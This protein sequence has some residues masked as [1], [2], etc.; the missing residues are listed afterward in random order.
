MKFAGEAGF[1]NVIDATVHAEE[2]EGHFWQVF[3]DVAG[4]DKRIK[5]S[6]VNDGA[7]LGHRPGASVKLGFSADLAVALPEGPLAAE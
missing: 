2:F 6:L 4:G 5:M 3:L 1:D 7:A